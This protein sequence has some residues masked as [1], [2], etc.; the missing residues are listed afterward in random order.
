MSFT[1]LATSTGLSNWQWIGPENYQRMFRSQFWLT[2]LG[3]TFVYAIGG[4]T[5]NP[6]AQNFFSG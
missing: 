6:A 2:I 5:G 1:D 3:N 4:D